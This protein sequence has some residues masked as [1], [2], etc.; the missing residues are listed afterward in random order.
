MSQAGPCLDY[1]NLEHKQSV[2]LTVLQPYRVNTQSQ[3]HQA[4]AFL[5]HH[6]SH[7]LPV[8]VGLLLG[9]GLVDVEVSLVMPRPE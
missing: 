9:D 3:V 2:T 1:N 5:V 4:Q 7:V 8:Y 6:Q